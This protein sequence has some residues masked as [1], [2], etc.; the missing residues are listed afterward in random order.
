MV[1]APPGDQGDPWVQESQG[2]RDFLA[3]SPLKV[4]KSTNKGKQLVFD[5]H[6]V[7]FETTKKE[8]NS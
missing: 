4:L 6:R 8:T 7:N 3:D 1:Q 2:A 5:H